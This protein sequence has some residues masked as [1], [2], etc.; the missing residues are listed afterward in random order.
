MSPDEGGLPMEHHQSRGLAPLPQVYDTVAY[1]TPPQNLEAE[2]ALLGAIL[3]NNASFERVA[4]ILLPEHFFEPVHQRLYAACATLIGRGQIAS[5]VTL[6]PFFEQ[7]GALADIGGA[8]YLAQLAASVVTIINAADY[9]RQ[10]VDLAERRHLIEI[11]GDIVNEAYE[12]DLDFDAQDQIADAQRK[13]D[14]LDEK[15][16]GFAAM[17]PISST[18][19][20]VLATAEN[21]LKSGGK[22][23]GLSTGFIALDKKLAGLHRSD[24]LILS[25]ATSMG[26][27]TLAT[28]IAFNVARAYAQAQNP[29]GSWF[30]SSGGVVAFYSQEM[31]AEQLTMRII[32]STSG[33]PS[34]R[35]RQGQ[36]TPEDFQRFYDHAQ[37]LHTLPLHI[38]DA[39]GQTIPKI[40]TSARKLR[41]E[42]GLDLIVVDYLQLMSGVKRGRGSDQNRTQEVTEITRGLK[43]LAKELNVPVIALSQ[44][45]R[46][47][48]QREDPRPRNSDLRE[49]GSIEQDADVV[50]FVY[51]EEYYLSRAE[52]TRRDNETETKYLERHAEWLDRMDKS[53]GKAE[54]IIGKQRH[55]PVG[56]AIL[57]FDGSGPTFRD[58]YPGEAQ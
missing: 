1:R 39:S 25:G 27:T 9:G 43:G 35:I 49:S 51:R 58:L 38:D 52:P 22:A 42:H 46:A 53:R 30:T 13:L 21:A 44:L 6:K 41:R 15:R 14:E 12:Q 57:A 26:K 18:V 20:G 3:I 7:D 5:P 36:T 45:S 24:L 23:I 4:D 37:L 29:D 28:N 34:E 10:I 8:R 54:A 32:S 50:I 11:G 31:S 33:V 17:R 19:N 47:V 56:S 48:D 40:R 2:Q 16:T 55:G